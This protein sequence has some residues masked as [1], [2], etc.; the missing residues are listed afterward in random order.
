VK[1][2]KISDPKNYINITPKSIFFF[3]FGRFNVIISDL[4][5][6]EGYCDACTCFL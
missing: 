4:G 3:D 1:T 2:A 5:E 6:K